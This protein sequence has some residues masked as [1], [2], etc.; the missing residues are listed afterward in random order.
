MLLKLSLDIL[1]KQELGPMAAKSYP[2][3]PVDSSSETKE[4]SENIE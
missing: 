2:N 3:Q 1:S 4:L